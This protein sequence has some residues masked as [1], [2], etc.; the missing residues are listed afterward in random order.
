MSSNLNS[1][2]PRFHCAHPNVV[3]KEIPSQMS[4]IGGLVVI[5]GPILVNV[6]CERSPM[7]RELLL[8]ML[9]YCFSGKCPPA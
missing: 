7:Q 6:V 9:L 1:N 8:Q 3:S 5:K 2:I 4:T